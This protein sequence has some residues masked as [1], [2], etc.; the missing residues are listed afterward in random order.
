[1]NEIIT[2]LWEGVSS[3][4]RKRILPVAFA[5]IAIAVSFNIVLLFHTSQ[6]AITTLQSLPFRILVVVILFALSTYYLHKLTTGRSRKIRI[7]STLLSI[8]ILCAVTLLVIV[9]STPRKPNRITTHVYLFGPQNYNTYMLSYL[10]RSLKQEHFTFIIHE[11]RYLD[12]ERLNVQ[13]FN[14]DVILDEL[15]EVHTASQSNSSESVALAVV[16]FELTNNLFGVAYPGLGVISTNGWDEIQEY[17]P[18]TVY[19]YLIFEL[20]TFPL[21]AG[22][23]GGN[24]QITFHEPSVT[25]GCIFDYMGNKLEIREA[26]TQPRICDSHKQQIA[27]LYGQEVLMEFNEILHFSWMRSDPIKSDLKRLYDFEFLNNPVSSD[28]SK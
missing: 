2:K 4:S 9:E 11:E 26:L 6:A 17:Q 10:L 16:S 24:N 7:G 21:A 20:T 8:L 22:S 12:P 25:F 3:K 27:K 23:L 14:Y 1:M 19:E 28:A 15:R 18:L 5:L 13:G